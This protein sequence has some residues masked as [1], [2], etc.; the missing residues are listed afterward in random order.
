MKT[1]KDEMFTNKLSRYPGALIEDCKK[2][3]GIAPYNT[4]SNIVIGDPF[5]YNSM[6]KKYG[7]EDVT[8]IIKN[9]K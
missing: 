1:L 4:Y 6:C 5:F 9:L 3:L 8:Y 7:T 2:Y